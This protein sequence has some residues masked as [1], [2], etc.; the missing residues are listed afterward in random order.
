MATRCF[1]DLPVEVLLMIMSRVSRPKDFISLTSASPICWRVFKDNSI[2]VVKSV[3]ELAVSPTNMPLALAACATPRISSTKLDPLPMDLSAGSWDDDAVTEG[4]ERIQQDCTNFLSL[5]ADR[6][7]PHRLFKLCLMTETFI[8]EFAQ[9]ALEKLRS[10]TSSKRTGEESAGEDIAAVLEPLSRVERDRLQRA[11][12]RFETIRKAFMTAYVRY[13]W[14]VPDLDG[15]FTAAFIDNLAEWEREEICAVYMFLRDRVDRTL[16]EIEDF[17]VTV[18]KGAVRDDKSQPQ[19]NESSANF[20]DLLD[21][22]GL[23]FFKDSGKFHQNAQAD[24]MVALGLPFLRHLWSVSVAEQA[25]IAKGYG[26]WTSFDKFGYLFTPYCAGQSPLLEN[27]LTDDRTGGMIAD[28]D[29]DIV[30]GLWNDDIDLLTHVDSAQEANSAWLRAESLWEL[31]HS[32]LQL[33]VNPGVPRLGMVFWDKPRLE[34]AG[35]LETKTMKRLLRSKE[36]S[37]APCHEWPSVVA[38]LKGQW[39]SSTAMHVAAP[40]LF[41]HFNEQEVLNKVEY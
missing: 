28:D 13:Q 11:F 16:D 39:I 33:P 27:N 24:L 36:G 4:L 17:F 41:K 30:E 20:L 35:L 1:E 21:L 19:E 14:R 40:S 3:V 12:L 37:P 10:A 26:T 6:L 23:R 7:H 31:D 5:K 25:C 34:A 22:Y 2:A 38:R 29:S 18:A 15:F 8:D 32:L 9:T